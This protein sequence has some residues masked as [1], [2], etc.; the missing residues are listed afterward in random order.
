MLIKVVD[1]IIDED[2]H[3]AAWQL[4]QDCLEELN[5]LAVQR[6]MMY[7]SE[8]DEVMRDPRVDKYL[9][10]TDDGTL[11]GITTYTNDLD[12]VPLISPQYFERHWPEHY[13]AHKIWYIGFIA[14]SPE[15]QGREAFAQM[16]EQMYLVASIQNGLVGLDICSYNDDVRHMSR[17]FR[18]MISR[19]TETMRFNRIDQQ[20]SWLY[21]FPSAA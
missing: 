9:A 11:A 20:S 15:H 14:V 4:Y 18:L 3:S 1:Q 12:A 17:V 8:F 10:L 6:H 7:K 21:E 2:L 16:V 19:N 13:A 5:T